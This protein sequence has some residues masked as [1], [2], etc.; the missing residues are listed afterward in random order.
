M[1]LDQRRA[2]SAGARLVLDWWSQRLGESGTDAMRANPGLTAQVDQ[3]VAQIRRSVGDASGQVSA[4]HL[5]AYADGVSDV[6]AARGW[7]AD[8]TESAG[9]HRASWPSLHLL[10]VCVLAADPA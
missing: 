7:S 9:W 4:V 10:A 8:E 2:V 6:A 5:A 1:E 3:H